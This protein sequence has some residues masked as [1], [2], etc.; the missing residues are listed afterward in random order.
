MPAMLLRLR[1][2]MI[3]YFKQLPDLSDRNQ[4]ILAFRFGSETFSVFY[5]QSWYQDF[6]QKMK[7]IFIYRT[8][9][10][11]WSTTLGYDP[12]S[13]GAQKKL[14][15]TFMLGWC[16]TLPAWAVGG[17]GH[18][19]PPYRSIIITVKYNSLKFNMTI[20]KSQILSDQYNW[21]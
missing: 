9:T 6:I 5:V 13:T 14:K 8:S 11:T 2:S 20:M 19:C 17:W 3:S 21:I 18:F 7:R 15:V 4:A 16:L 12:V 1:L 10:G